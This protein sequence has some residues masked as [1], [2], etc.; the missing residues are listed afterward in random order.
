MMR[1]YLKAF[2]KGTKLKYKIA[3]LK[4]SLLKKASAEKPVTLSVKL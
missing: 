2:K 1:A 4:F 3:T